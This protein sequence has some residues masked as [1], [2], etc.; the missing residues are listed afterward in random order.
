MNSCSARKVGIPLLVSTSIL[1]VLVLA[2]SVGLRPAQMA[3]NPHH[4][5][6]AQLILYNGKIITVDKEFSVRRAV[7]AA[8]GKILAVGDDQSILALSGPGTRI[9]DLGG[10]T[11][12]PGLED[13]HFHM[14][15]VAT[16]AYLGVNKTLASSVS[17]MLDGIRAKVK[18]A[19]PGATVYTMSGWLPEQ[20]KEKRPPSRAELDSVSPDNPVVVKGGHTEYLNSYALRVL[21]ITRD[22]PSPPGGFVQKDPSTGEPTGLLVDNAI[23]LSRKLL[24]EATEQQKREALRRAMREENSVGITSIREPTL[25]PAD[26]RVYQE[27]WKAGEMTLRVSMNLNLDPEQSASTII[28]QLSEWGVSTGFGDPFLRL[29]GIG[30]FGIDGGFQA[31]LMTQPYPAS[32]QVRTA[33]PFRGLQRIPTDR[34]DEV[35][36]AMNGLNWRP[37]V[38]SVGDRATDILLD[39]YEKANA[40]SS[41]IEKR[42]VIEH[43]HYMR[44]DQFARIK[45]LGIVISTQFHPYMAAQTMVENWGKER[46]NRAMAIREWLDAGLKV[47]GGSDWTL[48][49]ANP[50]WMISF[51]VTRDTRLWGVLGPEEKISRREA[52]ELMTINNAYIT[53]E[54]G[55]K[56]SIEPGK[57]ADIVVLSDDLFSVPDAKIKDIRPLLTIVGGR[58]VYRDENSDLRVN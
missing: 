36:E 20:L 32:S 15:Q 5:L 16:D 7:A 12:I 26:M 58:I 40:Q 11:V 19:P 27:L 47:G 22:T 52:L 17:E 46:A 33:E 54:E 41:I 10:K 18:T 1:L 13:D 48:L 23:S 31:A 21:G 50:F 14:L 38:H 35:V 44:P 28:G 4:T 53:F 2:G 37:C 57:L 56:G 45:K 39:A 9:I 34:F 42:W 51:F 29:D 55:I 6:S 43:G 30:E 25:T 49:P 8:G 3:S 24:P